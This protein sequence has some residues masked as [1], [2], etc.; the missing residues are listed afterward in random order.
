MQLPFKVNAHAVVQLCACLV[1]WGTSRN[2]VKTTGVKLERPVRGA[3]STLSANTSWD[4]NLHGKSTTILILVTL[5]TYI[6]PFS[7][8]N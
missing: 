7:Y 8:N 1:L 6:W 2:K 3:F 5:P 4:R